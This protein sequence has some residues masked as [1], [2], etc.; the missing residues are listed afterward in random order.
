MPASGRVTGF[1]E[2][3]LGRHVSRAYQGGIDWMFAADMQ[4]SLGAAMDSASAEVREPAMESSGLLDARY[5]VGGMQGWLDDGRPTQPL[6]GSG[7][8]S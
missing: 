4:R 2:S 1:R 8:P 6:N 7:V 3:E 5:L